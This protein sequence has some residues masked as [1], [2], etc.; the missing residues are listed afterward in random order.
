MDFVKTHKPAF[1][2]HNHVASSVETHS[3]ISLVATYHKFLLNKKA[4]VTALLIV[5]SILFLPLPV[6]MVMYYHAPAGV[7]AA[8]VVAFFINAMA[9]LAK[10]EDRSLNSIFA[11]C[12]MDVLI[13]FTFLI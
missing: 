9:C 2:R 7:T 3:W 5:Q 12:L 8:I 1:F 13:L 10:P 11:F 6:L 4:V